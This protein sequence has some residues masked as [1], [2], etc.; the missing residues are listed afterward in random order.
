LANGE[1]ANGEVPC[2]GFAI[3]MACARGVAGL[4]RCSR[5]YQY[6]PEGFGAVT[7]VTFDQS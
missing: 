5:P 7:V 1:V 3:L 4:I 6:Q 2:K